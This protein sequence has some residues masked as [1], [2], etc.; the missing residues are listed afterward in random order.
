MLMPPT[1]GLIRLFKTG[2]VLGTQKECSL[3]KC[4]I[5]SFVCM[6]VQGKAQCT[7]PKVPAL[8]QFTCHASKGI[9]RLMSVPA[10]Y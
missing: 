5:E 4:L 6:P 2:V 8:V 3:N 7:N 1:S 9:I 10:L